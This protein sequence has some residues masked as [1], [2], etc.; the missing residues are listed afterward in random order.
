MATE[1]AG[2]DRMLL[3]RITVA[4]KAS[5]Q[6]DGDFDEHDREQIAKVR[7]LGR[8]AGR[9][10]G[11]KVRTFETHPDRRDDRIVK[12]IVVVE[13]SSPIHQELMRIRNDKAIRRVFS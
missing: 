4:L 6:W 8:R 9:N 1:L 11:W 2:K 7:S 5:G 13:E 12:V 3:E 10:L